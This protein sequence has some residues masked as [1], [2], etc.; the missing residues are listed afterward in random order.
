MAQKLK[1]RTDA[2]T[3]I[4]L[5]HLV[6]CSA[7]AEMLKET[8]DITF[9]AKEIPERSVHELEQ[10]GFSLVRIENEIDFLSELTVED[11]VLLDG[12]HFKSDYQKEIKSSGC[13]LVFIDDLNNQHF[14]ADAIINA[15][16]SAGNL[17]ISHEAYTRLLLGQ[18]F[19]LLRKPFRE[20]IRRLEPRGK[21]ELPKAFVC[22]GGSDQ[23]NLTKQTI[24][25][26][27]RNGIMAINV[28]LGNAYQ[29]HDTLDKFS[30]SGVRLHQSLNP[31]KMLAVMLESDFAVVQASQ[32]MLE[33]FTVGM[34]V[35]TG[36]YEANQTGSLEALSAKGLVFN[37]GNL[38]ENYVFKLT[39]I[40]KDQLN[41]ADP[42]IPLRQK[43]S[44]SDPES[45]YKL[46]F[47]E[48]SNAGN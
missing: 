40:L 25:I 47:E 21:R 28:V 9:Y 43:S 20:Q 24:D 41:Q 39:G 17:K 32:V 42:T 11:I 48:L 19:A 15:G 38:L 1:I 4:G 44:V 35:I 7:L 37:C 16:V 12:Y 36:Y 34:P 2:S 29:H 27:V 33:L 23:F 3:R 13:K 30:K 31:E 6:R 26:L 22:F 8:F 46:F 45:K 18:E 14:V 10:Y 5:G